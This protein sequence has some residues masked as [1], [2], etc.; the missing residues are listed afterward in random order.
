MLCLY[1]ITSRAPINHHNVRALQTSRP[2]SR[3]SRSTRRRGVIGAPAAAPYALSP[4]ALDPADLP[5]PSAS[6]GDYHGS[7]RLCYFACAACAS[8]GSTAS[9]PMRATAASCPRATRRP[10]SCSMSSTTAG[11][12]VVRD[13]NPPRGRI[14]FYRSVGA[15]RRGIPAWARRHARSVATAHRSARSRS[16]HGPGAAPWIT[17]R[18]ARA[19]S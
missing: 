12:A 5:R 15:R 1:D 18:L 16:P 10:T 17:M 14:S 2:G 11:R 13:E 3:P 6:S 4:R 7:S 9:S 19:A 8:S